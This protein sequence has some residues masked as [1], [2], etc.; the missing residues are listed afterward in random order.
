MLPV[1]SDNAKKSRGDILIEQEREMN[2]SINRIVSNIKR[3]GSILGTLT[4][5]RDMATSTR[6]RLITE[7]AELT[8]ENL[9]MLS[10]LN[11]PEKDILEDELSKLMPIKQI[12]EYI[13]KDGYDN[14][15]HCIGTPMG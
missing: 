3:I 4:D 2:K 10:K 9:M 5:N 7:Q 8:D 11:E 13:P 14:R 6:T 12:Q 15:P 1:N